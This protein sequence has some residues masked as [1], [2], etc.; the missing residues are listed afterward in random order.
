MLESYMEVLA[1]LL[2]RPTEL[3]CSLTR[4]PT[5]TLTLALTRIH[6]Y[7]IYT[8]QVLTL[9]VATAGAVG[10]NS[11]KFA[12]AQQA[13]LERALSPR[14]SQAQQQHSSS[15]GSD[16]Y[17]SP[18]S[19]PHSCSSPSC[20]H[21]WRHPTRAKRSPSASLPW[22]SHQDAPTP[23]LDTGPRWQRCARA[24]SHLP[25]ARSHLPAASSRQPVQLRARRCYAACT[26]RYLNGED[27]NVEARDRRPRRPRPTAPMRARCRRR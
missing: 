14:V 18:P 19:L 3:T 25:A 6:P 7:D 4:P 8:W 15:G 24:R 26:L 5:S 20:L 27:R 11:P 1:D 16:E 9:L 10:E 13:Q 21:A 2:T 22:R 12:D 23:S 17:A